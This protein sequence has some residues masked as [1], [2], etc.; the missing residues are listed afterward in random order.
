MRKLQSIIGATALAGL[1]M[2]SGQRAWA[3]AA[4][5]TATADSIFPPWQSGANAPATNKG[6]EFTVPQVNVLSDFHGNPA[7]AKLVVFVA[8]NYYFAM[9]PLVAAFT[10]AHPEFRGH[11]FYETLPPG[12]LLQQMKAKGTITLGNFTLTVMPDVFAAGLQKVKGAITSGVLTGT[13]IPYVTNDLTI[14]I[15]KGNPGHVTGLADLGKPEVRLAMPNPAWEGVARQIKASLVKAGGQKLSDAVYDTKVKAGTTLLTHIHH[16]QTPLILMQ[17]R[18]DAGVTWTSEAI[19]QEQIGH[20]IAHVE[21]PANQ[22][23]TAI[24]ASAVVTGAAHPAAGLLWSQFLATP[25]ALKI[26]ES[27]GFKAWKAPQ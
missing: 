5:A 12:I 3:Q 6:L 8:G 14:M 20:A 13:A 22:N 4:P 23:T 17:G 10:Q 26:F 27:Y 25:P 16:R 11:V 7:D 2:L 19:F 18:A 24:Y 9:A 1:A 15:A 21:I